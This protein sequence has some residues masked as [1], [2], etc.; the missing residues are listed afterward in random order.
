ML[1]DEKDI[2]KPFRTMVRK[3]I[4]SSDFLPYRL[5]SQ[6]TGWMLKNRMPLLINDLKT[7]KRFTLTKETD[8]SIK[9]LLSVP[10]LLKGKMIGLLTLINKK[11]EYCFSS[12]DQ[13][14]LSII[15]AQSAHLIE[16]ARLLLKEEE[17]IRIEEEMR[18][19]KQIQLNILPRQIPVIPGYDVYAVNIPAHEVSGD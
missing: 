13:R 7:D 1:L 5:D 19:A 8:S 11:S 9:T 10:L 16:N 18:M 2:E 14:L 4:S 12:D 3:Q 17:L 6:L 15:A